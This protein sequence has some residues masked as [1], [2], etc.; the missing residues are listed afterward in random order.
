MANERQQQSEQPAFEKVPPEDRMNILDGMRERM[1]R[2]SLTALEEYVMQKAIAIFLRGERSGWSMLYSHVV[3]DGLAEL[4]E[5]NISDNDEE[6]EVV[7]AIQSLEQKGLLHFED[8]K[9]NQDTILRINAIKD[10]Q[11]VLV[12]SVYQF[13]R[14]RG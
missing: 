10:D 3:Q 5:I 8:D 13:E 7:Q 12:R 2:E 1:K 9:D 6:N 11:S 14:R 4:G